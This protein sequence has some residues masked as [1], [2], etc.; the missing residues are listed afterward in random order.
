M[1]TQLKQT[2][3][4]L[5]RDIK[6]YKWLLLSLPAYYFV[7]RMIFSAFCPLVI[8]TGFP[9]PGCGMTRAFLFV[10]T[11]QFSRAWK[12]NPLVYGWVIFF[13]YAFVQRYVRRTRIKGWQMFLA[14]LLA[15]MLLSFGYRM[16]RYFPLRPPLSYTR[17]NMME[18][19]FPDY[20]TVIKRIFPEI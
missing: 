12:M 2:V 11:G 15:A 3:Q 10:L 14:L 5:W 19:I 9:C 7:V 16:Y 1:K 13:L 8:L 6:E 20:I 4:V 17:G 18:R